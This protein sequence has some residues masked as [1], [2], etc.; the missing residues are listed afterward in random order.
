MRWRHHG[1]MVEQA[2]LYEKE[3]QFTC[4]V[5]SCPSCRKPL[6][7]CAICL[8]NMGTHSGYCMSVGSRGMGTG[9]KLANFTSWFTWCQTC[10]H[11]G[12]VG[13]MTQW[14]KENQECPVTACTCR[15]MSLDAVAAL[16]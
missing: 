7:R 5:S 15:C 14:F 10:R 16:K 11:G 4:M 8:I 3:R 9:E 6:P 13:H 2:D 12:H 1:I